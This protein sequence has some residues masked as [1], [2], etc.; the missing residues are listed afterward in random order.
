MSEC[1]IVP[2][3]LICFKLIRDG[4]DMQTSVSLLAWI[5]SLG[6]TSNHATLVTPIGSMTLL[7]SWIATNASSRDG[8]DRSLHQNCEEFGHN[9]DR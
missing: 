3:R 8:C 7:L 2:R 1:A 9:D 6:T 5:S 4:S